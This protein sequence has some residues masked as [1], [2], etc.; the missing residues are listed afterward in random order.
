MDK[1]HILVV[2]D[3]HI[4]RLFFE[5][6]LKRHALNVTTAENGY[7]AVEFCEQRP[8]DLILMDIRMNGIDGIQTAANIKQISH[9]SNTPIL[10]VSAES[11]DHFQHPDF[12]DSMLKPI[13]QEN[14]GQIINKYLNIAPCFDQDAALKISHNDVS[15]VNRLRS[16]LI[17]Q[18]PNDKVAVEQL[19][20]AGQFNQLDALLHKML[21]S[22]KVCAAALL[23]SKIQTL[24]G[25]NSSQ[26]GF[27]SA[28]QNLLQ[29][30]DKTVAS[31]AKT[32]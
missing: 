24:K 12:V 13:N 20:Q 8:F 7:Q 26:E 32:D 4:N 3:N 19:H 21:G 22:A 16:L 17:E 23:I 18:L 10:A 15:I 31:A 25:M 5:S 9:C 30:I 11:F 28:Y 29:A 6:S 2:D 1:Q 27:E 14:L